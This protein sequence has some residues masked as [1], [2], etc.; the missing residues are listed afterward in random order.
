MLLLAVVPTIL[1]M[2]YAAISG[3]EIHPVSRGWR[4]PTHAAVTWVATPVRFIL[5]GFMV[6][7]AVA[8]VML[9]LY[10]IARLVREFVGKKR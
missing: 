3:L 4:P 1:F 6:Y 10:A 5:N 2:V 7:V 8:F 9:F